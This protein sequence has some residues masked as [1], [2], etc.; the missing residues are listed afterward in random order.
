[1]FKN[2]YNTTDSTFDLEERNITLQEV[3]ESTY[4]R[5]NTLEDENPFLQ[6]L[7]RYDI[8]ATVR[9][10]SYSPPYV[11]KRE[12][13]LPNY[14]R[15]HCVERLREW[16][17]ALSQ[18][19]DLSE[20]INKII[21]RGY[22]H[23]NPLTPEYIMKTRMKNILA[24]VP[25]FNGISPISS[26]IGISGTGKSIAT[27]R[28]LTTFYPQVIKHSEFK[29]KYLL[30][31]QLVWLKVDFLCE[32]TISS[33]CLCILDKIDQI[34]GT[35]YFS[36]FRY[37]KEEER[38]EQVAK[39]LWL[40][41]VG[42]FIVDEF[43]NI[44]KAIEKEKRAILDFL[45][46]I[47]AVIGIPILLIGTPSL[48][49]LPEVFLS[50]TVKWNE[51]NFNEEWDGLI[52]ELLKYQWTSKKVENVKCISK[53]LYKVSMGIIDVAIKVYI[54]AQQYCINRNIAQLTP[55]II[56]LVSRDKYKLIQPMLHALRGK[57]IKSLFQYPDLASK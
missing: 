3:T 57:N 21:I 20:M 15:V 13:K 33:F 24:G 36:L 41:G 42:L 40:H 14:I 44:T 35:P 27:E 55:E 54:S 4:C 29:K 52:D 34:L 11:S 26:L 43:Q 9:N 2:F 39:I 22:I 8:E 16:I 32:P 28:I 1:M 45:E 37:Q 19:R 56:L 12:R 38:I 51:F 7:P 48:S 30:V 17:H 10:I 5:I 50:N 31:D 25:Q 47:S 53:N 6:F 46:K 18:H 23:R 49:A